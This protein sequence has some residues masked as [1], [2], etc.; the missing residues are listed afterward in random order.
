MRVIVTGGCGF[1]GSHLIRKLLDIKKIKIL[2]IDK[3]GYA[4]DHS[5]IDEKLVTCNQ[6][7]YHFQKLDLSN[8]EEL[9]SVVEN[10]EPDLIMHLAAESH[11]DRS[12]DNPSEF[13]SSNI[14]GTYNLLE[15]SRNYFRQLDQH[16]RSKFRFHHI[17][18][19]E[20]FG[21]LGELGQFSE[22]TAYDPRS[23]YSASK[24]SS[25]HLVRAWYH[26]Y[27]LPIVVTNCSNNFGPWQF[28][29]KLIPLVITKAINNEIIPIYGDGNNIRDWLYVE[30]HVDGLILAATKGTIGHSYCIGG[31][32]EETNKNI[33]HKI[34][35]I[36][37]KERPANK[38][39]RSLI[40][41]VKDRPGHDKRYSI[42]SKKIKEELGWDAHY[43]L[44]KGLEETVKWYLEHLDW[45]KKTLE[46][47]NYEGE[48]IGLKSS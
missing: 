26:T 10:F 37:D 22:E 4:S 40:K 19:D 15:A 1:I 33:V 29:E 35:N 23:P 13:I 20:V 30:D 43:G 38:S 8:K 6:S 32:G 44:D 16:K 39:Y 21:S 7:N 25:D 17:S 46:K 47:S 42:N 12:I 34:C 24:A 27:N 41:F 36:L 45:V 3:F 2:N 18:T 5:N 31:Y 9:I 48:R 14:I 28:P 11:V